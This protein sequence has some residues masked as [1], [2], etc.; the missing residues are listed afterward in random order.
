MD[1]PVFLQVSS[2]A[3]QAAEDSFF[4]L[5][6]QFQGRRIDDQRCSV[7]ILGKQ[8]DKSS[9]SASDNQNADKE[10]TRPQNGTSK[11]SYAIFLIL[12]C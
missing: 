2:E 4:D 9:T 7:R 3:D 6:S 12:Y 10:N 1:I 8:E 11:T 5:L